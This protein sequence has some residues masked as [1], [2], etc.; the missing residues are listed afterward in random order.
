MSIIG[1]VSIQTS[2]FPDS[3]LGVA[4]A[5][6]STFRPNMSQPVH[7]WFRYSAGFSA[8]WA[9]SVIKEFPRERPRVFDPFAGSG[10]TLLA[11]EQCCCESY[12]LEAHPFIFRVARTK[13]HWR[14]NPEAYR[15]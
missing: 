14:S 2:L 11:A 5:D 3:A 6:S 12:G 9:E 7:R 8:K 1:A 13:L 15:Q 4:R 10:T